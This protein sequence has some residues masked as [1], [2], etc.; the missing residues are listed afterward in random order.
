[1]KTTNQKN[2]F[3]IIAGQWRGRMLNF[4]DVDDI[5]PTADRVKETLFNW[6]QNE[7]IG[8]NCLDVF[9]GSGALGFEAISRGAAAVT[10]LERSSQACQV[11]QENITLL[12][13]NN[14]LL[15]TANSL[16]WLEASKPA[17]TFDIVFLDPPFAA[18]HLST[19]CQLLEDNGWLSQK[20]F[21]YLEANSSLENIS[22]PEGWH[23]EKQK[24]AGQVFYGYAR[25]NKP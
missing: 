21:I 14:M 17:K 5:R 7:I 23:L 18:E 6:L 15:Q 24:K 1:M 19:C 12:Q 16:K 10:S 2:R 8:A 3:R 22:L 13:T 9:A 20:A 11:I 25:R 4:A